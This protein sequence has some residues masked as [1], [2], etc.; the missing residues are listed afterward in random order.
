MISKNSV[1]AIAAAAVVLL[2]TAACGSDNGSESTPTPEHTRDMRSS[3]GAT[4][5]SVVGS[6]LNTAQQA[7]QNAINAALATAPITFDSG[8]SDLGAADVATIKAVAVPLR[9]NDAKIEITTYAQ[10]PNAAKAKSLARARGDNIVAEL[11]SEGIDKARI[12]VKSEGNP[13]GADLEVDQAQIKVVG[14]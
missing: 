10:D 8:S 3:I 7:I 11:E 14:E 1:T 12:S 5:S 4:A 13:S 6:A 2:M 9:G